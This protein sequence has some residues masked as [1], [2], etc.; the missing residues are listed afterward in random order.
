MADVVNENEKGR[1]RR[2]NTHTHSSNIV[3]YRRTEKRSWDAGNRL[4][5][6]DHNRANLYYKHLWH[7]RF[8]VLLT[9]VT[10]VSGT[11]VCDTCWGYYGPCVVV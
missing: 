3:Q 5:L 6:F 9:I 2:S 7:N 8:A 11:Y 4:L 1:E 10:P